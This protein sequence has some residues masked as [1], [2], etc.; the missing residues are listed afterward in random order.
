MAITKKPEGRLR[1]EDD[2]N[3]IEASETAET[4]YNRIYGKFSE[5]KTLYFTNFSDQKFTGRWAKQIRVF[6]PGE[7][8]PLPEFLAFHFT[9]HL[10]SRELMK[11]GYQA[12]S[13]VRPEYEKKALSTAFETDNIIDAA[14][15]SRKLTNKDF[16]PDPTAKNE[17]VA[18]KGKA[19]DGANGFEG[20]SKLDGK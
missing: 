11:D 4:T 16:V 7:V 1:F 3:Y 8:A 15:G 5:L 17:Q 12:D 6:E 20:L 13:A 10:V 2:E 9:K 18:M 19:F 14:V